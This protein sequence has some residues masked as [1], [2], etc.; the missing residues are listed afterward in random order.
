M[1]EM[2][3][4]DNTLPLKDLNE[5]EISNLPDKRVKVMVIKCSQ[6]SEEECLNTVRISTEISIE[7]IS[8]YQTEVREL[9]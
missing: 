9:K 7:T 2:K 3:E 1:S 4:E 8:K 6:N 5:I